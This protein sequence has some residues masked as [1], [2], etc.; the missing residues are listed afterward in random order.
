MEAPP[1]VSYQVYLGMR[2]WRHPDWVGAFYPPDMPE[3]WWLAFYASQYS[4]LW[5]DEPVW[6]S[7]PA[8]TVATCL[9]EVPAGFRF[10][11]AAPGPG[12]RVGV[13]ACWQSDAVRWMRADDARLA[14]VARGCD[15]RIL[16]ERIR[17]ASPEA[18]L[19]L[20]SQDH[21]LNAMEQVRTVLE[22]LGV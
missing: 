14:W 9:A 5:L 3:E 10:L 8:Q 21:D 6:R 20:V 1:Q 4:C 7:L 12:E 19:Y 16:S 18:P 13:P 2:D 11:L 15:L 17:H 22:L